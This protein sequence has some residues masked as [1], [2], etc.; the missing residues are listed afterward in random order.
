V[1]AEFEYIYR[2]T[3]RCKMWRVILWV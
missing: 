1:A 2:Y 3:Y